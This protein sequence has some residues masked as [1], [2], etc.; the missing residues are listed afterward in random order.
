MCFD[1]RY[2]F[3]MNFLS[4]QE[5]LGKGVTWE[6]LGMYDKPVTNKGIPTY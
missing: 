6:P 2:L 3:G 5:D 4:S 1:G